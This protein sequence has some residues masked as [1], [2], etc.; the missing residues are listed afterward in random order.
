MRKPAMEEHLAQFEVLADRMLAPESRVLCRL[1][2]RGFQSFL[3]DS[4]KGFVQ[5]YD[6]RFGKMM[7]KAASHVLSIDE[8]EG[9]Y[10]FAEFC[11]LSLLVGRNGTRRQASASMTRLVSEASAKLS[12][13]LGEVATF[14]ATLYEFQSPQLVL[15]YFRWRQHEAVAEA[16]DRYCA[17]V[18]RSTGADASGIPKLLAGLGT[19]EK[20][21]ILGQNQID[22]RELPVWQRRGTGIIVRPDSDGSS[23]AARLVVNT[24]LPEEEA[25]ALFL[26]PLLG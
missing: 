15:D 26:R 9:V 12:L 7:V 18:L 16:L 3:G 22:Y 2:G 8:V 13:L 14:D 25:Y 5:P 4:S 24:N 11:E 23:G 20:I 6:P 1:R 21:E 10:G 17:H 19:D